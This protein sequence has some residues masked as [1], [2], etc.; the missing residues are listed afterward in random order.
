M[1]SSFYDSGLHPVDEIAGRVVSTGTHYTPKLK[2]GSAI[3]QRTPFPML[4]EAKLLPSVRS[5]VGYRFGRLKVIGF[6]SDVRKRW[7]VRCACGM[8]ALRSLKAIRNPGNVDDS[9]TAC[10]YLMHLQRRD[11]FRR[12]GKW[13]E[14]KDMPGASLL[15]GVQNSV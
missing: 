4:P 5:F 12:T 6:C 7:V 1:K 8:Y 3:E 14:V 11:I 15:E 2:Q 13:V 10:G 9:C